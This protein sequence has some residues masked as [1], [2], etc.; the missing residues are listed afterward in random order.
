MSLEGEGNF[1]DQKILLGAFQMKT[2]EE[3]LEGVFWLYMY[4]TKGGVALSAPPDMQEIGLPGMPYRDR[5]P[6]RYCFA[7]RL[8]KGFI[9]EVNL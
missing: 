8:F 5:V 3:E 7:E 9:D 1:A 4:V 6:P 2:G